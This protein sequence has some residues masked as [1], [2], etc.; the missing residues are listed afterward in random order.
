MT[1]PDQIPL[2]DLVRAGRVHRRLY[3]DPAIFE[4]ELER[5]FGRTWIYVGHDSQ[6]PGPGDFHTTRIGRQPVVMVRHRDG[7]VHVLHNR[8][9]HRG[10]QVVGEEH[11]NADAFVCCYHGWT[12]ETDGRIRSVPLNHGYPGHFDAGADGLGMAPLARVASYRGFVFAS[13]ADEG[14]SLTAFLGHMTTSFDDM[15]DRAPDGALILAGGVHKHAYDGNWKLYLENLC[16]AA[17][18]IFVHR[19]SIEAA[20]AQDDAASTDGAGEI[21]VRQMRQN[22]APYEFWEKAVGI[23]TYPNGHSYLGDYHDDERLV[24]AMGDPVFAEY[25]GLLERRQGAARAREILEVGRWNSNIY[26]NCSFMSQFRQLRVV[27]P[28]AVDRTEVHTFCFRMA[29][30]PEAMFLDTIRF[31]NI[32]NG[33]GSPVLTDDLETYGRI[34]TGL[35]SQGLEWLEI[36]RGYTSDQPDTHGGRRG[37]NATSEIYIRNMFEAWLD[38]MTRP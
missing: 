36:G 18:P 5:I 30:A 20:R 1:T 15:I 2:R 29:G 13:M 34:G 21:A 6:V 4:L 27:H 37:L 16:D 38:L 19:S 33:A 35:R 26:P 9:A 24:A 23:W 28:V 10:A 8:C 3:T 17:H 11:G 25:R 14:P 22:G 31:A 12:Y 7:E 32:V